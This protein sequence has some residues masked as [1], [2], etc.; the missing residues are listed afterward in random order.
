MDDKRVQS[1]KEL[2]T[3]KE[4]TNELP[5][6][7][8]SKEII[9]SSREIISDIIEGRDN[10]LLVIVGPCSIHDPIGAIDYATRLR[11]VIKIYN[12]KLYIVMRTY[13]EKPRTTVGWKG[14]INDPYI[15]GTFK[16][17]IGLYM[18]RK[19]L[20]EITDK[21]VPVSVELLDTISPQYISDCISWGA[22][23]ARTVESQVHRELASGVS[24]PV[25][26]KNG[27]DGRIDISMDGMESSGNA[28]NFLGIT[29]E[30]KAAITMTRGNKCTHI[31]LRGSKYGTNYDK[32]NIKSVVSELNNRKLNPRVMIDCSHGNSRKDYRNQIKVIDDII[33]GNMSVMGVMIESNI[34]SGKQEISESLEYGKSITDGC[35]DW[36]ETLV[37]FKKLSEW[38]IC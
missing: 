10:R 6:T 14:L 23:G 16:I 1:Y 7:D 37:M 3:P 17:N 27:T 33:K 26:F 13:F 34:Q 21:G 20:T 19:L 28:H 5:L 29:K 30:G 24:F 4:L 18:A 2:K 31:I 38:H 9:R 12:E 11:K 36:E 32:E 8:K 25:G 22:I 35:V 15:D